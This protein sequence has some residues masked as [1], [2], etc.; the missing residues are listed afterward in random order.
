V[1]LTGTGDAFTAGRDLAEMAQPAAGGTGGE[2]P[3]APASTA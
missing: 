3:F 1:I 2:H